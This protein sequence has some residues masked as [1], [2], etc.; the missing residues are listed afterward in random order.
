MPTTRR[1]KAVQEGKIKE[2]K[3]KP[4]VPKKRP[5]TNSKATPTKK[6]AQ[7]NVKTEEEPPKK[8]RATEQVAELEE[9]R[10]TASPR[11]KS[12]KPTSRAGR[13]IER[14]HIYFFYRPKVQLEEAQSIDDVK[15]FH[16]L[17]IPR[18]PVYA[19]DDSNQESETKVDP[20]MTEEAEMKVLSPGADAVPA[21]VTRRTTKQFHRVISIGKK[22]L[23]DP[24]NAGST[25]RRK[26]TFWGVVTSVGDDLHG[27]AEGLGP[28]TY[29]TKT[30]G[31]RHDAAARLVARGGYAIV[32]SEARTPSQRETHLGYHVSHPSKTEMGDVQ[33]ELGIHTSSSFVLQVKNPLAPS[34]NPQMSHSKQAEYPDWIM[35]KVFGTGGLRGREDYGLRFASCET[36]ELLD[37]VGAQVL[38][39]AARGGEEGLEISL[40]DGRGEALAESANEESKRE[41]DDV[42]KEIGLDTDIFTK[43]TLEGEWA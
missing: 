26:E 37:A 29:E 30:R 2:E 20:S 6:H 11:A 1:Q 9:A 10:R 12:A 19:S 36:P 27:L 43:E 22:R 13:T 14:G 31:T 34:T 16:I 24:E 33:A 15:N 3:K 23:P 21:P 42:F 38:M 35:E 8:K 7:E 5:R 28:K 39:I 4:T 40:G 41:I 17:L 32:N 18:P 25:G